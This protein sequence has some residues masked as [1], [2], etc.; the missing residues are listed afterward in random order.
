VAIAIVVLSIVPS[1][2]APEAK[3]TSAGHYA[4]VAGYR[5]YYE[6]YGRGAPV[7]LLHGG[8]NTIAGSFARQIPVLARRYRVI[9]VEQVGHGHTPDVQM[10]FT[11]P[12]MADDTAEFL[13]QLKIA[14]ADV[15]GW[16]DGGIIALVLARRHPELVRRLVVSGVNVNLEG[17]RPED[18]RALREGSDAPAPPTTGAAG[19]ANDAQRPTVAEK[20][21]QLWL[22]P[23]VLD[24]SDLARIVAPV[25]VVAGDHDVIRLEHTVEIFE[26][27]PHAELCILPGTGHDTFQSAARTLNPLILRFLEEPA[28]SDR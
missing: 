14:P 8:L 26:A 10:P 11:Y 5:M 20:V 22:T 24:Q 1:G 15:V 28:V 18:V 12:Q 4:M 16:S 23:M 13:R 25:L 9:A 3:S 21:R 7:V 2:G 6:E 19:D 17:Q 27:L